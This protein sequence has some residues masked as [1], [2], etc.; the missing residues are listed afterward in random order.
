MESSSKGLFLAVRLRGTASD[1]PNIRKTM[2]SLR[3]ERTFQARIMEN[4][5]SNA[6]MLRFAKNLVAWGEVSPDLLHHLLVK[7]GEREGGL[8]LDGSFARLFGR[9]GVGDLA[10][11]LV[12]GEVGLKELWKMGLKPKFRLHPPR[13][14]FKRS[15]R[16]AFSDGGELGYR[17]A[18]I[19]GL[20]KRMI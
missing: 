13:G 5:P 3:L 1:N 11:G 17:G 16:R 20:V 4:T 19:N 14:G 8:D 2:D 9:D 7:R 15:L 12:A 10:K 6:G 18:E